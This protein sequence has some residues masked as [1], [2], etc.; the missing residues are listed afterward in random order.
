MESKGLKEASWLRALQAKFKL[1]QRFFL[2]HMSLFSDLN[3]F[4]L[5]KKK[6]KIK[7][8]SQNLVVWKGQNMYENE[9]IDDHI[10][11]THWT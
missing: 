8:S 2:S 11:S 6:R 9:A 10:M 5:E 1:F 3:T 4:K 7:E